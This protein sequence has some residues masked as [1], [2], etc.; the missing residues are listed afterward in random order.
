MEVMCLGGYWTLKEVYSTVVHIVWNLFMLWRGGGR[1]R[2]GGGYWHLTFFTSVKYFEQVCKWC[3]NCARGRCIPEGSE[4]EREN[5]CSIRQ[6]TVTDVSQCTERQ[7][8]AS[9][10]DKCVGLGSCVWTRQVLLSCKFFSCY[11]SQTCL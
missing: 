4:C 6:R 7:C 11:F 3:S 2:E 9:D 8:P 10:C 1:G 5:K